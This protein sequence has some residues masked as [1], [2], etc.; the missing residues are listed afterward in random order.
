MAKTNYNQMSKPVTNNK[1]VRANEIPC[2]KYDEAPTPKKV[3]VKPEVMIGYVTNCNRLR[4]REN[5]SKDAEIIGVIEEQTSVK[6]NEQLSTD[7]FY[8][9]TVNL[10][11]GEWLV[12]YSLK[13]YIIIDE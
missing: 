8:S 10:H 3:E 11:A 6:I 7:E 13:D 4:V 5:P 9:V 2:K 1:P 12:G